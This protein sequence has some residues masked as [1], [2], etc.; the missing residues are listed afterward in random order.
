M[1]KTRIDEAFASGDL[2]SLAFDHAPTGLVVTETRV[3]RRCNLEFERMF[4]YDHGE[5]DNKLFNRLY[6]SEEIF[7]SIGRL[8]HT[9]LIQNTGYWDER[10]MRRKDGSLFWVRVRGFTFTPEEPLRRAVWSL[11]DLSSYRVYQPITPRE[12]EVA[13]LLAEGLTTKEIARALKISPRTVEVHRA[14]L[15]KKYGVSNTT[16]LVNAFLG[17]PTRRIVST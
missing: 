13:N 9:E 1:G 6:P 17:V 10:V 12:R 5:L 4:G 11:A 14:R 7:Q 2:D 16:A 3:I 15:Q 8:D